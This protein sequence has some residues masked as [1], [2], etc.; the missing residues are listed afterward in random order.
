M[1]LALVDRLIRAP[2]P[3]HPEC[4]SVT[5]GATVFSFA[6]SRFSPLASFCRDTSTASCVATTTRS[7]TPTSATSALSVETLQLRE[8]SNTA[9]PCAA[10][11]CAVLVRQFPHRMPGSDV[12][13]AACRPAPRRHGGLFHHRVVDRDRLRLR[14]GVR[15]ER[16]E[17]EIAARPWRPHRV[18]A[19]DASGIDVAIFIEQHR[20]RG[21]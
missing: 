17:T 3:M 21:T 1:P 10:L 20:R 11:P 18:T 19:C 16:D 9:V 12:G 13:P 2:G 5:C 8:S 7:S 4:S 14:E 15:V 6:T